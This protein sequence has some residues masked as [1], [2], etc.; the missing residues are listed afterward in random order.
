MQ[1]LL[2]RTYA[3]TNEVIAAIST[4]FCN[5]IAIEMKTVCGVPKQIVTRLESEGTFKIFA[6][7]VRLEAL[8]A[9]FAETSAETG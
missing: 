9:K 4:S 7:D 5:D 6:T 3:I 8:Y 2:Y 1:K